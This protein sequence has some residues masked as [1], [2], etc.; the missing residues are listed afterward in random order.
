MAREVR[1]S[2]NN[3]NRSRRLFAFSLFFALTVGLA[4]YFKDEGIRD[5]IHRDNKL[6]RQRW[7]IKKLKA[8]NSLLRRK[9]TAIHNDSYLIEKF[10]REKL[11]LAK[12]NE[13][14]FRFYEKTPAYE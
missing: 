7:T 8:E 12:N 9:I 6:E 13:L 10:A 1:V 2:G 5:L 4:S 11:R 3:P 14:I